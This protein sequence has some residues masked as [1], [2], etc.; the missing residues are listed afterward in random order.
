VWAAEQA[1][2]ISGLNQDYIRKSQHV[3]ARVHSSDNRRRSILAPDD[4]IEIA[5]VA[6]RRGTWHRGILVLD[7][8][9][10]QVER[11]ERLRRQV[12]AAARRRKAWVVLGKLAI[13]RLRTLGC[14]ELL[15]MVVAVLAT[16][17]LVR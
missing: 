13:L 14:V 4:V 12:D 8:T 3:A 7:N 10:L 15:N 5:D 2:R 16:T 1:L 17:G 9:Q 11:F 6:S